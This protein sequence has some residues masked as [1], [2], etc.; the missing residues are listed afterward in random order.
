[1]AN[2]MTELHNPPAQPS[3]GGYNS[4]MLVGIRNLDRTAATRWSADW[5]HGR[6]VAEGAGGLAA[7][8]ADK[9]VWNWGDGMFWAWGEGA[10]G[11]RDTLPPVDDGVAGV[12]HQVDGRFGAGY[13]L[14]SDLAQGLWLAVV[15]VGGVGALRRRRPPR[16]V[17]L[18]ALAVVGIAAF[19][20]LFQGRSR[21]L[22]TFVPLVVALAAYA[23]RGPTLRLRRLT[24][25]RRSGA[26]P[27]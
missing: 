8:Y 16:D 6:W 14:R 22:L 5:I 3:Y 15:L 12:V 7:F 17:V 18:V 23:P 13:P 24:S 27:S 4:A 10:D 19:T 25:S 9:A 1:V 26:A 21:Y 11:R 20:L 2:G